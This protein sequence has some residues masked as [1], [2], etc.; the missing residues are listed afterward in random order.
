MAAGDLVQKGTS[1][2]VG[3][4]GNTNA[5]LIMQAVTESVG[6]ADMKTVAGEQGAAITN[7][8]TNPRKRVRLAGVLLNTG[9]LEAEIKAIRDLIVGSTISV[10]SVNCMVDETPTIEFGAEEARVSIVA[11]KEDSMTYT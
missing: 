9:G 2:T 3:F 11:V 1:V 7:I 6:E 5:N 4:N 10:N 8:F